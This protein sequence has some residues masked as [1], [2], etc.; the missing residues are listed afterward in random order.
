MPTNHEEIDLAAEGDL[1]IGRLLVEPGRCVVRGPGGVETHLE[2][3][4]MQ[5]LLTLSRAD[6]TILSREELKE[7][8]WGGR[9]VSDDAVERVIA[10]IRQLGQAAG[11]TDFTLT[12]V[13]KV[14][15]RFEAVQVVGPKGDEASPVVAEPV[16]PRPSRRTLLL[17]AGGATLAFVGGGLALDRWAAP[18]RPTTEAAGPLTIATSAYSTI[19]GDPAARRLALLLTGEVPQRLSPTW[20]LRVITSERGGGE[21]DGKG[22]GAELHLKGSVARSGGSFRVATQLIDRATG[23]VV[24]TD[25]QD[26]P[27]DKIPEIQTMVAGAVVQEIAGRIS[28]QRMESAP[29]RRPG[30]PVA[31]QRVRQARILLD[32]GR[33]LRMVGDEA[34]AVAATDRAYAL[35][36]EA[37]AID[38]QDVGALVMLAQLTRNG[39]TPAPADQ[40]LT[41]RQRVAAALEII[42]S[43]LLSDPNDPSALAAL[44]DYYRRTEWRWT[45]AENLFRRA[46]ATDP[47]L[48][49]AHWSYAYML[50]TQGRGIEGLA[51]AQRLWA[52][53][54]RSAWHRLAL[55]RLLYVTDRV[56][57]AQQHYDRELSQAPGNA[58]LVRELY[59]MHLAEGNA[60]ALAAL[61]SRVQSLWRER[62]MPA[63]IA[64]LLDRTRAGIETLTGR[65]QRLAAI[66]DADVA[67]YDRPFFG[68]SA[69]Q[70]GRASVDLL[71]VYAMEYAW[72]GRTGA[73][74]DLLERA[75][76]ARSL[77]WPS[78]LP[79]GATQFP[80]AVRDD[81]RYAAL[82]R[83][84][85]GLRQLVRRRLQSVR[86]R[87]IAGILPN[88]QRVTPRTG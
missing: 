40:T 41:S 13:P 10:R 84:H 3:K 88:G 30:D 4:I 8:C 20:G 73:A 52:L 59:F 31:F 60:R 47:D 45:E 79:F 54:P 34:G 77:Y 43:A 56:A 42:R 65:P 7:R 6:R 24:W 19:D 37:L 86:N 18:S 28:P 74:I 17:A 72:A 58:F 21:G 76:N 68:P 35:S 29:P 27:L 80:R 22:N 82:W 5:V 71:Y 61:I 16:K 46:L 1:R 63:P 12:T 55:P 48:V 11:G 38:P 87:Q 51:H 15:Y 66:V 53:R 64:A 62:T 50:G 32:N 57:E 70:Q 81:P 9:A 25:L 36:Q 49:E 39:W 23:G 75:L 33:D 83:S 67:R 14:G 69:T 44:G 2:P 78:T 26:G 85:E